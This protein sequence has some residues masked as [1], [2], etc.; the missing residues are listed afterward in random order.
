[1]LPHSSV[2]DDS[3]KVDNT[4]RNERDRRDTLTPGSRGNSDAELK[5]TA[6]IRRGLVGSKSLSSNAKNVKVFTVGS[7]VTLRG[8]V[9]SAEEKDE[10]AKLAKDTAGVT[11][12][13]EQL[14]VR[15]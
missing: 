12:V 1:M 15:K 11:D 13:D 8:V 10:I 7:K 3:N 4:R 9:K 14:E 2:G 6:S 5:I